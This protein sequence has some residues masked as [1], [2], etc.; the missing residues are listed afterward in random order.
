MNM[1][2][3]A[4]IYV[5]VSR[6][7][8]EDD[9]RVTIAAQLA[10]CEAFC[11]ERGYAVVGRFVDKDKYRVKGAL[12]NP[13]GTRKDR[14]A[15][16]AMLKAA[17]AG[18]FDII[19]AWKE[20]RLYRGAY[21]ALPLSEVLDERR[22]HLKIELVKETFD[23]QMLG[24]KA[25]IAKLELD[26]IRDRMIMGRKV[27]IER[28]EP[29]G[30][31]IRYGYYKDENKRL[32][33]NDAEASV[34]SKVFDWYIQGEN[35]MEIRR[36]LNAAGI[37]PR[38][39]NIWSKATISNILTFE[40]YATGKYTTVLDSETF[41]T[42]CPPIIPMSVWE[43][44]LEVREGNKKYRGRNVKEDYLCRGMVICLCGWNWTVRTCR[45]RY[46]H[47]KSGYYGCARKDHQPE[48]VHQDCPGTI[49]AK[50]LDTFVWE[51]VVNICKNP[52]IVQNAIDTKIALLQ[53]ELGDIEYEAN[54]LQ[55]QLDQLADEKQWVITTA[56]K[57][58][59]SEEDMDKQLAAIDLQAMELRK[60]RDDKLA[61]ILVQQQ[62][63]QLKDWAN[64]YLTNLANGL[65]ILE[66]DITELSGDEFQDLYQA[67][68]ATRFEE[69]YSGDTLAALRWAVLEEK[70]KTVRM[71]ISRVLVVKD[72]DGS[73]RIV[74]QLAFELPEGF[75][76]LVYDYQSLAYIEQIKEL[77]SDD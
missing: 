37:A 18:E 50:K 69:K 16:L 59:I 71:L 52:E 47:G 19:V 56:R 21:A 7:Y 35:N 23:R 12:V 15:Y 63:E 70:R 27:R 26:N 14:P 75:A 44:S 48:H 38:K 53:E 8:K 77:V 24:I 33:I 74:P 73:K 11:Q 29:A 1:N 6:A 5:R 31:P 25:A 76:S 4:A 61:A 42:A 39:N 3:K 10:D 13:S 43:K 72:A 17:C 54:S 51:F 34:V 67:L 40:G 46:Q 9:E 55:Y 60:M 22:N 30:G 62:T 64:Q 28:G 58:K 2:K 20:D 66:M 32:V 45:G 57:G 68:G 36:R 49:G 41:T 65:H